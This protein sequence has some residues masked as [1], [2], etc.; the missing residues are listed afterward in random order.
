MV[1]CS[2]QLCAQPHS[3]RNSLAFALSNEEARINL[4]PAT[5]RLTSTYQKI[6][7]LQDQLNRK[8]TAVLS[9][10]RL[11][12]ED[13]QGILKTQGYYTSSIDGLFG[14]GTIDALN[15]VSEDVNVSV[16]HD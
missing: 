15:N 4:R 12:I 7:T 11:V 6:E 5:A 9:A 10:E 2:S 13:I 14:A 1:G 3:G 16:N 8:L